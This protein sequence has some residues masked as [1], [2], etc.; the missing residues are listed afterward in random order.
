MVADSR[1]RSLGNP[2]G[3][4]VTGVT[5]PSVGCKLHAIGILWNAR[6]ERPNRQSARRDILVIDDDPMMRDLITDWLEGAGYHVRRATNCCA[7][8]APG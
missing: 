8:R 2:T 7:G 4:G 1:R 5:C 6:L 3:R